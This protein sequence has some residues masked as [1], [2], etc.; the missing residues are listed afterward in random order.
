M[1]PAIGEGQS[2]RTNSF[3]QPCVSVCFLL[4][5]PLLQ[6]H[7]RRYGPSDYVFSA[8][9]A[10]PSPLLTFH[11]ASF[12]PVLCLPVPFSIF[13]PLFQS[14]VYNYNFNVCF[15][16]LALRFHF[17]LQTFFPLFF[18]LPQQCSKWER[19]SIIDFSLSIL[20]RCASSFDV[21]F[22]CFNFTTVFF[23][24]TVLAYI[25]FVSSVPSLAVIFFF[26]FVF[27]FHLFFCTFC[28]LCCTRL[29]RV[30]VITLLPSFVL[31]CPILNYSPKLAFLLG[32]LFA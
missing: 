18:F 26:F 3:L 27:L 20:L 15:H 11:C 1:L 8:V 4:M 23:A 17:L 24:V 28:A 19:L 13:L 6:Q 21:C 22:S 2:H 31:C 7:F 32:A 30:F 9:P 14:R 10:F 12:A 25:V 5:F 29:R 16:F